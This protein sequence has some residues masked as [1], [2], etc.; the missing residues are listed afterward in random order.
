M[1][2][3]SCGTVNVTSFVPATTL[4]P[5]LA[6]A[7]GKI[8]DGPSDTVTAVVALDTPLTICVTSTLFLGA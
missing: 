7:D 4:F 8:A 5:S 6:A 1:N 2:P 3:A